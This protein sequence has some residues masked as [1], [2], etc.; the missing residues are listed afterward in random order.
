MVDQRFYPNSG[1]FTLTK[2]LS[3]IE[4]SEVVIDEEKGN[5][6]VSGANE[7]LNAKP[8]EISLVAEKKYLKEL[9]QTQSKVVVVSQALAS[10]VAQ[11]VI[12]IITKDPQLVFIE[13]L[14]IFYPDQVARKLLQQNSMT[15]T[16]AQYEDGVSIGKNS[17]IANNVEIGQGSIIAPNVV[18]GQGV[19][20]GRNCIIGANSSIE[21]AH[22]GDNVIIHAGARIGTEGFGWLDLGKANIKIPQL[23]RV[24]IQDDVEVGANTT[25]DRG[26]LGDTTIGQ[27]TKIDNLVQ[28]GHNCQIGKNCL[29]AGLSGIS[30]STIIE[31]G[32]LFGGGAGTAGHLTIGSG[33]MI[34]GRAAV[35]KDWPEKSKIA[36]APAQDIKD[37]WRE[38]AATRRLTRGNKK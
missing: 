17:A 26:A 38:I 23:G 6:L 19:T 21:F 35:T 18:I 12:A 7:L 1:P 32:V 5:F 33:S 37:F 34:H 20:I 36:G 2:L 27:N 4:Q 8:D 9:K 30:G 28:I 22:L 25:I 31:D 15:K 10:E 24:I 13:I 11:D 3:L 16:S 14:K 29:I